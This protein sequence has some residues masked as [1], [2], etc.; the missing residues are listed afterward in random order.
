MKKYFILLMVLFLAVAASAIAEENQSDDNDLDD[1]QNET[2]DD[3]L[4][5]SQNETEDDDLDDS[6]NETDDDDLDDSQNETDDD[7][8][9]SEDDDDNDSQ[10]ETDDEADETEDES[11]DEINETQSIVS[12]YGAQVRLLQLEKHLTL[13]V[14][15]GGEV[16][17]YIKNKTPDAN[18][19][20]LN[21]IL[22][23]IQLLI[24]EIQGLPTEGTGEELAQ[25]FVEIKADAKDLIKQFREA[26]G[27]YLDES[28]KQMLRSRVKNI[29]RGILD[30]LDGRI[31]NLTNEHN[32]DALEKML[33]AFGVT[34]SSIIDQV[35]N[36]EMT[37]KEA[38]IKIRELYGKLSDDKKAESLDKIKK[39]INEMNEKKNRA[40]L[41]AREKLLER[42]NK[43]QDKISENLRK[44]SNKAMENG[45]E[46]RAKK[47]EQMSNIAEKRS[48]AA[49]KRAENAQKRGE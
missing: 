46:E 8:G 41:K 49:K 19:T 25:K 32:A 33:A 9:D 15:G 39:R 21:A 31:H 2:E 14:L 17:T 37:V 16:I 35:R 48:E 3:D 38:R 7:L 44:R 5:D 36:G 29:K 18:V 22:D 30:K 12:P 10:N 34:N 6:Q 13:A 40:I 20:E 1:S 23:N 47:L 42:K 4:D 11:D 45:F 26:A 28:D 24:E 43:I 27:V